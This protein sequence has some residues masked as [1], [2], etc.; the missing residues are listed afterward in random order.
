MENGYPLA[1]HGAK[2][3]LATFYARG[4][5]THLGHAIRVPNSIAMT[6]HYARE[7]RAS[8]NPITRWITPW[9]SSSP[10]EST[11]SA[12][13]PGLTCE[14]ASASSAATYMAILVISAI[15]ALVMSSLSRTMSYHQWRKSRTGGRVRGGLRRAPNRC[16][17]GAPVEIKQTFV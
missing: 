11:G 4:F 1:D 15:E 2:S 12:A 13:S 14:K 10:P 6:V 16:R 7:D 3:A 5:K 9:S 8:W 17:R